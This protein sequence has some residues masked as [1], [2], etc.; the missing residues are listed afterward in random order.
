MSLYGLQTLRGL[1]LHLRGLAWEVSAV[2]K[3]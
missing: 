3:G 1:F 2:H